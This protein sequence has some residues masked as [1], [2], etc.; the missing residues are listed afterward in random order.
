MTQFKS[1]VESTGDPKKD[2]ELITKYIKNFNS[3][4]AF[5]KSPYFRR[6]FSSINIGEVVDFYKC[7]NYIANCGAIE[8]VWGNVPFDY[9]QNYQH[10]LSIL[11]LYDL[12]QDARGWLAKNT[13]VSTYLNMIQVYYS[14]HGIQKTETTYNDTLNQLVKLI[15]KKSIP[16]QPKRWRLGE[17]HDHISHIFLKS[18]VENKKHDC[19]FIPCP[20][21]KSKFKIYQPQDTLQLAYWGKRVHN[22]VLSYEEK[23]FRKESV[24][25]LVEEEDTPKY[26]FELRYDPLKKGQIQISQ[27]VG[28]GNSDISQEKSKVLQQFI[29]EIIQSK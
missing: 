23:I 11:P 25:I 20:A 5:Y 19:E 1:L 14:K 22:C 9:F 7:Y 6:Y 2:F 17:F 26:T 3:N 12:N 18:T 15:N 16:T 21:Q 4:F 24:I 28:I 13:T 27:A 8:S 10:I 29:Q